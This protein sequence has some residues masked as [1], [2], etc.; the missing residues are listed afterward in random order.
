MYKYQVGEFMKESV[1]I[2]IFENYNFPQ[3][4]A[5]NKLKN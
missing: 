4:Y 1:V 2:C 5:L 3:Y